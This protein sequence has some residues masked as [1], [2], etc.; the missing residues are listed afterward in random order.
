MNQLG[1]AGMESCPVLD[2]LEQ[3]GKSVAEAND[4]GESEQEKHELF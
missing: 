4:G 1:E 3:A 2:Q